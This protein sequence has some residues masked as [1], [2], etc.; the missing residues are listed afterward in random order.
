MSFAYPS[1]SR[2]H[3]TA[4]GRTLQKP[5]LPVVNVGTRE[6]PTYLPPKVRVVIPVQSADSKLDP[7]QTQQMIR[8]AVRKPADNA[9]SIV[10]EGLSIV[11]LS[12]TNVLL[13]TFPCRTGSQSG[14]Q[15]ANL[16]VQNQ[17]GISVTPNLITVPGQVLDEPKVL[18]K[19]NKFAQVRFGSWNMVAVKFNTIG[20][21]NQ[22]SYL[23]ISLPT[24][25]NAFDQASLAAV[26][27]QFTDTLAKTGISV[28]APLPGQRLDLDS[29]EDARLDQR[30]EIAAQKLDLLLVILPDAI[31]PLY[32]CIKH[33]GD[34]KYGILAVCSVGHKFAKCSEQYFANVALKF[35]LKLGGNNQL[36]D[37]S[38][39]GLI[40]EDK[41]MVVCIDVTH[42]SP[43]SA[44]N[45]AGIAGMVA[46][47]DRWLGQWPAVL[48]IQP[49][50]RKEMV[51][52]VSDMHFQPCQYITISQSSPTTGRM[53]YA[54]TLPTILAITLFPGFVIASNFRPNC[55]IPPAGTNFTSA[56]N[57][58]GTLQ[59]LWTCLSIFILCT[60]SILHLNIP[61]TRPHTRSLLQKFWWSILGLRVKLKW[62]LL[63]IMMPEFIMGMALNQLL[64]ATN[65]ARDG[66]NLASQENAE[67]S[68]LH[69]YYANMGGFVLDFE[70][71]AHPPETIAET[72]SSQ[73]GPAR[74]TWDNVQHW[75]Q[76]MP[77]ISKSTG[78]NRSRMVHTAWALN[79]QQLFNSRRAGLIAA[80]P[81][82]STVQLSK[83][84]DED[85]FVKLLALIQAAYL[86]IELITRAALSLPS[87]QLEIAALAYACSSLVT[88]ML[89]WSRPRGI[90]S[91][92]T[93][94]ASRLPTQPEV[95]AFL[96]ESPFYLWTR[97][98]TQSR[99][100]A[101]MDF[102]P[103]PNDAS[104]VG[105]SS[106]YPDWL[107]SLIG[108]HNETLALIFGAIFGGSL[109]GGF[110][111]L[112]WNSQFPTPTESLL[113]KISSVMTAALPLVSLPLIILWTR[114]INDWPVVQRQISIISVVAPHVA[115]M[116]LIL[117]ILVPYVL[118][119]LFLIVDV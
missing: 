88:Y 50:V 40:D 52:D 48:R 18:Y 41:T 83:L 47:V 82:I 96:T 90:R 95:T 16:F 58:R 66:T 87:S 8:F 69:S 6:K 23:M 20:T 86:I 37:P 15:S 100:D 4:Y 77:E 38:R 1:V 97:Y 109:F 116:M 7:G 42:P 28:A 80:L 73:Q 19:G 17:F 26:V 110:H 53:A 74:V 27:K 81:R 55:T 62:M 79:A 35:N 75:I 46:S 102:V 113:W 92:T 56:P 105:D 118:A 93:L 106:W 60:W 111:C 99:V 59:I 43:G 51:S 3:L 10:H 65:S 33:C 101:E 71:I 39:R 70:D 115:G 5:D 98:R 103:M 36:L 9:N 119:R 63:N 12:N 76:E 91:T 85:T 89:F 44:A 94:R 34:V 54:S 68:T 22:W 32:N 49:N 78:I 24:H 117:L 61:A 104:S 25:R 67:W 30:L 84:A 112:A 72:P 57:I 21:L 108:V 11:G 114:Q 29:A 2:L 13:V 45:V 14:R 31:T 107:E 64:S